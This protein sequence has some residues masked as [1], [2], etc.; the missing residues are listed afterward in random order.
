MKIK[1]TKQ[2][3][4]SVIV[5]ASII[6]PILFSGVYFNPQEKSKRV[7][8]QKLIEPESNNGNY[9]PNDFHLKTEWS[10]S[11]GTINSTALPYE[12]ITKSLTGD[13]NGDGV[14]DFI[15]SDSSQF[16]VVDINGSIIYHENLIPGKIYVDLDVGDL[17][18]SP[19]DEIIIT[20]NDSISVRSYPGKDIMTI[21]GVFHTVE[22]ADIDPNNAYDE[23]I[24]TN[25]SLRWQ[26]EKPSTV[27]VY[28]ATGELLW[29]FNDT[30]RN[31]PTSL[32]YIEAGHDLDGDGKKDDIAAF[33]SDG[34]RF[35]NLTL[36]AMNETGD[37]LYT[38]ASTKDSTDKFGEFAIG[39]FNTSITGEEIAFASGG[40]SV[41]LA[42]KKTLQTL[43]PS[44]GNA[45]I[46][47]F[48]VSGSRIE[49]LRVGSNLIENS[50]ARDDLLFG[51]S[52]G[53]DYILE[54]RRG[55]NAALLNWSIPSSSLQDIDDPQISIGDLDNNNKDDLLIGDDNGNL[56]VYEAPG[57]FEWKSYLG[58]EISL[59]SNKDMLGD[60]QKEIIAHPVGHLVLLW[61]N[62]T[63][64][65][66]LGN[67]K[68]LYLLPTNLDSDSLKETL[69]FFKD[70]RILAID[71][72]GSIIW[73]HIS[74]TPL[75]EI[76]GLPGIIANRFSLMDIDDDGKDDFLYITSG[77]IGESKDIILDIS[78]SKPAEVQAGLL[79]GSDVICGDFND[80]DGIK[81]D[82]IV[83]GF[84]IKSITSTDNQFSGVQTL[85]ERS[86]LVGD[87]YNIVFD[88]TIGD[89]NGDA[90]D[91]LA[92]T[93]WSYN[94]SNPL[95]SPTNTTVMA[96]NGLNG[97]LIF[98]YDDLNS[99]HG[100]IQSQDLNN[101]GID[102]L[103]VGYSV[104]NPNTFI[105]VIERSGVNGNL[106]WNSSVSQATKQIMTG[107]F[108]NDSYIDIAILD[109]QN[110]IHIFNATDGIL[111][112]TKPGSTRTNIAYGNINNEYHDS[113]L[114]ASDILYSYSKVDV[115]TWNYSLGLPQVM[116]ITA[117]PLYQEG[118]ISYI[119]VANVTGGRND[120]IL[121]GTEKGIISCL[122]VFQGET[123][124]P[125]KLTV[126]LENKTCIA[127]EPL[128][129][130]FKIERNEPDI[131]KKLE[132][133]LIEWGTGVSKAFY[134]MEENLIDLRLE[135]GFTTFK[136]NFYLPIDIKGKYYISGAIHLDNFTE[137]DILNNAVK[138]SFTTPAFD[139]VGKKSYSYIK[140]IEIKD[141][142]IE[143]DKFIDINIT[144]ENTLLI[145]DSVTLEIY[146][147]S[148]VFILNHTTE[149]LIINAG[150]IITIRRKILIPF[151]VPGDVLAIFG[152]ILVKIEG[153]QGCDTEIELIELSDTNKRNTGYLFDSIIIT[154][155]TGGRIVKLDQNNI[156][157]YVWQIN[158][159]A[160]EFVEN[161]SIEAIF[162]NEYNFN[163]YVG[164]G[165]LVTDI[166]QPAIMFS[167]ETGE[168]NVQLDFGGSDLFIHPGRTYE[169][170]KLN[171]SFSQAGEDG[172]HSMFLLLLA[173]NFHTLRLESGGFELLF[174]LTGELNNTIYFDDQFSVSDVIIQ[175]TLNITATAVLNFTSIPMANSNITTILHLQDITNDTHYYN[176]TKVYNI[177][178]LNSL[179]VN[180]TINTD[181]FED[182][183]VQLYLAVLDENYSQIIV[184]RKLN[185]IE[186]AI[187]KVI[188]AEQTYIF[189]KDTGTNK[190][191]DLEN[192]DITINI[193]PVDDLVISL[194]SLN[195][196]SNPA[197]SFIDSDNSERIDVI[198]YWLITPNRSIDAADLNG[199]D[200]DITIEYNAQRAFSQ[201]IHESDLVPYWYN[202]SADDW[203]MISGYTRNTGANTISFTI[204]HLSAFTIGGSIDV[205]ENLIQITTTFAKGKT[206]NT[207]VSLDWECIQSDWS[208]YWDYYEI[209]INNIY[210]KQL[211]GTSDI[212][213]LDAIEKSHTIMVKGYDIDGKE[214]SDE[215]SVWL[216]LSTVAIKETSD[217]VKNGD[218]LPSTG[219]LKLTWEGSGDIQYYIIKV[220]GKTEETSYTKTSYE[221]IFTESG[222]YDIEIIGVD[223]F[224]DQTI[225]S[226]SVSY[227]APDKPENEI[228]QLNMN[229]LIGL[230]SASIVIATLGIAL[231]I[232]RKDTTV[233]Y[234]KAKNLK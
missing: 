47:W 131:L 165:Y 199:G 186:G 181:M 86:A 113:D 90:Y 42:I 156:T 38:W 161:Y 16:W 31:E 43:G 21:G 24:V 150:D 233:D 99:S 84:S 51:Y 229:I 208:G 48:Y 185:G 164:G 133:N 175:N 224:G 155:S 144:L 210:L 182:D 166:N 104:Y 128:E 118:D 214:Y 153:S 66:D 80:G 124:A 159:S 168:P 35:R 149:N 154:N 97:Q 163:I 46:L 158:R 201:R 6:L 52:S 4:L 10:G 1:K 167:N 212:I 108:S 127:G 170:F 88:M 49:K 206:S 98:R 140:N 39:D 196:F 171:F 101:D 40:A 189:P 187:I 146:A 37:L 216:D 70:N 27:Y 105:S 129:I 188:G 2:K 183:L 180:L 132:I 221:F 23:I 177:G 184:P 61:K 34:N 207:Q 209:Y 77:Q 3:L 151:E 200:L 178:G 67:S 130:L 222:D 28:N 230:V 45:S 25:Y 8:K 152:A 72:D 69:A 29:K 125:F 17:S 100:I 217:G 60:N 227:S 157:D 94:T 81:D 102:E 205:S 123:I 103:I 44:S 30:M 142:L 139:I 197:I 91:D 232:L 59:L 64:I 137:Y 95:N 204:S 50:G 135:P 79:S 75:S 134:L 36:F 109:W 13:F 57:S 172:L 11:F 234:S 119:T 110:N 192:G 87:I 65:L 93:F 112:S 162:Y 225:A 73:E 117:Y 74:T 55:D 9:D 176:I 33:S 20:T 143:Y 174:N 106:L 138:K 193:N 71:N 220:N 145:D 126:N 83:G 148:D 141:K 147:S 68:I 15:F 89:F 58:S 191:F 116:N 122:N 120:N 54:A 121:I 5:L 92:C 198:G 195:A 7:P 76:T 107:M 111:L 18:A 223:G 218:E 19:G 82:F 78:G 96:F 85:W 202:S 41:T 173:V 211:T 213:T 203:Q 62:Q 63:E 115:L 26:G 32:Y 160:T 194:N 231:L 114:V 14:E 190:V 56:I 226:F 219:Y 136:A 179:R 12:E 53:N 228:E 169:S 215:I 22:I